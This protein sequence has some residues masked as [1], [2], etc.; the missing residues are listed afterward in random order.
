[1]VLL[2]PYTDLVMRKVGVQMVVF[3]DKPSAE[4]GC[5]KC[6]EKQGHFQRIY[7]RGYG[8]GGLVCNYGLITHRALSNSEREGDKQESRDYQ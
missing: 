2:R 1:M 5:G 6:S 7:G 4:P 3:N 8:S